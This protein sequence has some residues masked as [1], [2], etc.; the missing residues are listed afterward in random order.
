MLGSI[1]RS[2]PFGIAKVSTRLRDA[3]M[4]SMRDRGDK[5]FAKIGMDFRCSSLPYLCP[6]AY[7]ISLAENI[8]LSDEVDAKLRWIFGIGTA[9][10]HQFQEEF[11]KTLGGVFQGWWKCVLCGHV[12]VGEEQDAPL[13]Y[14]WIP[15]PDRCVK[16]DK[17]GAGNQF[18]YVE[19]EMY[20]S[21]L[22]LSG[23]CDGVLVW[24]DSVEVLELKTI[25]SRG[26]DSVR[27]EI[28]GKP[29]PAHI[30][31][32]NAYMAMTGLASGRIVYIQKS[33]AEF[34]KV[35]CEHEISVDQ[36]V[37]LGIKK[38]LRKTDKAMLQASQDR[39]RLPK[40]LPECRR[41]SDYKAK[42]CPCRDRCFQAP[43]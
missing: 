37:V 8:N 35:L 2:S 39:D 23:H 29:L 1:V 38:L 28:G 13:R 24:P 43:E 17:A 41:R 6:R 33:D 21:N 14:K 22:R 10:H 9:I 25:G 11:L 12:H 42:G 5:K 27:P 4:E 32:L 31:Q 7:A 34:Q 40:R 20:S 30:M 18:E 36:S 26:F 16:C 19:L 15:M 3:L